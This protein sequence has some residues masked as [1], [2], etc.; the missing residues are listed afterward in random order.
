MA[1]WNYGLMWKAI[2]GAAP[3]RT[4]LIHGDM[5]RTW[6]DYHRRANALAADMLD[7]GLGKDSKVAQY[8]YN[9]PEY[10]ESVFAAFLAGFVPVNTNYR[11]G[12]EEIVYLFDNADAEAVVFHGVFA[13]LIDQVRDRLPKVKRW[14][15]VADDVT[16]VPAWAVAY[17]SVADRSVPDIV[18]P[19]PLTDDNMLFLYTGGTTGMP[20][21]VMW[22]H[23][24]LVEVLGFGGNALMGIAPAADI[25][26]IASRMKPGEEGPRSLVCCPLMHGTGQFSAFINFATGG[27]VITLPNRNLDPEAIWSTVEKRRA[28]SVVIVGQAFAGPMLEHL[29]AN[30]GRYDLS[31]V[32]QMGSSGVMWSQEN[33]QGL[34]E[35]VPQ[36]AITDSFGSSEAVG[37]GASVSV[38]GAPVKT[39]QFQLGPRCVVFTEDGRRVEPG[40]GERG[41][42]AVG[43][44]IP[45]GYYKDPEKTAATFRTFEGQ[46]WTVPGDWAEV[47]ADGT[48]HLLGRGSVC[49]NTGGEK[50]FPEEVEETLKKHPS[51]RDAVAVGI[52][53]PRFMETICA[54]VEVEGAATPT[55][56]ELSEHVKAHLAGYKA[57]RHL[58]LVP[59]IGRA[60]NGKVDYKRLKQHALDT[61]GVK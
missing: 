46:R 45:L 57:P 11:Y 31:S 42:V 59:T 21:G 52:P 53:D 60:P 5:V 61:L 54:V 32:V 50:V 49:I 29:D 56:E 1:T 34:L 26:E 41:L 16:E 18:P 12:P 19:A 36:M 22:R 55:L 40:S 20:K 23:G 10:S 15:M 9:S 44:A 48:L 30:P 14:Y 58:V 51:V 24:D 25:D 35:H 2:A 4:A 8:L 39:A 28:N 47:N 27:A 6:G 37:M 33:K 3:D 13:S 17:E 43:G 7:A 38:K